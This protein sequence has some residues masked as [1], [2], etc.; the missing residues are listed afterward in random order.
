MYYICAMRV[1][2]TNLQQIMMIIHI[3]V[4]LCQNACDKHLVEDNSSKSCSYSEMIN[5]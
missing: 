1:F 3:C 5:Y 2:V 4:L